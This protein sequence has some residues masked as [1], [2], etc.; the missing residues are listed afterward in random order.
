MANIFPVRPNP[1][2]TSSAISNTPWRSQ[3]SRSM[4]QYSGPGI[5]TPDDTDTGSA[6]T[7]T[8]VSGPSSK[9]IFSTASAHNTAHSEAVC[10]PNSHRY[11]EGWGATL[12]IGSMGSKMS[13]I[14]PGCHIHRQR[15]KA[16]A[17]VG[18]HD[19]I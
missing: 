13:L 9:I 17:V 19:A 12:T 15:P 1:L 11:G 10:P 4:G 3:M 8:T 16:D 2:I 5:A 18:T 14:H 7:A 6:I